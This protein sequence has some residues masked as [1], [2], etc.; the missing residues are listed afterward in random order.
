MM[1]NE[2]VDN[3]IKYSQVVCVMIDSM[4]AFTAMDMTIISRILAEGRGVVVIANKWDLID[5]KF[6]KKAVKWMEKQLE[7]GLG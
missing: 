2:Q 3:A 6:K 5:D 1:V 7:K 4:A